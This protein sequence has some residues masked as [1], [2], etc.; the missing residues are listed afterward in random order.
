MEN[1]KKQETL[2]A[3]ESFI[4]T[5]EAL[6]GENGCPWDKAQTHESLRMG[7]IEEA[8]EAADAMHQYTQE[9]IYENLVEELGDVLLQVMLHCVIAKEEGIFTFQEV[10]ERI[11]EKMIH[12]HPHVFNKENWEQQETKKT[13]D[14]LKAEEKGH[15]KEI[16]GPL[17][18]VPNAL[19]ALIKATKIQK[20]AAK[21]YNRKITE[22]ESYEQMV[23]L[24]Q[25]LQK[26][27]DADTKE[28]LMTSILMNMTNAAWQANVDLEKGLM[29]Q[30]LKVIENFEPNGENEYI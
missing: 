7:M 23:G 2:Q 26:T 5:I 29:D 20:R 21:E 22:K 6:R 18:Q 4:K 16:V 17:R 27:T 25:M 19:P 3:V 9:G 11:T 1:Q 8:Y 24:C 10:C 15:E 28:K 14:E 30:T 13:W 12:R